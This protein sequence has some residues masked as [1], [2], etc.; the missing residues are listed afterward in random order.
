MIKTKRKIISHRRTRTEKLGGWEG[1]KVKTFEAQR[2]KF[3][4]YK[5]VGAKN[6]LGQSQYFF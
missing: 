6:T 4:E 2:S 5:I 3:E 1:E